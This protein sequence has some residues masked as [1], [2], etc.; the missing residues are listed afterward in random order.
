[1]ASTV[2]ATPGLREE[3][4]VISRTRSYVYFYDKCLVVG[5]R[6]QP[7]CDVIQISTPELCERLEN[8]ELGWRRKIRRES[9][10]WSVDQ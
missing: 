7:R 10:V 9:F 1:M 2:A 6:L 5:R 3:L 4:E 8:Q